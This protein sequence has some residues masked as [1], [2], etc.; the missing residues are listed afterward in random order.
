MKIFLAFA[1][2]LG[3]LSLFSQPVLEHTFSESAAFCQL[4]SLGEVFYAMDVVNKQ[5]LIYDMDHTLLRTISL[6]TPEGYYL[7]DIQYVSETLFNS[8]N[9]VELVYIYSKYVPTDYSYYYTFETRLVNENGSILLTLPGVGFTQ[10]V[11]TSDQKKKFLA[12]EYNYSVI[13]YATKTHVYNLPDQST[14]SASQFINPVGLGNAYPNPANRQVFIPFTMPE[15]A[16]SG[17]LLLSDMNGKKVLSYPINSSADHVLLPTSQF[18]PGTY[19][20]HL[21]T[22]LGRSEGKKVV[23]R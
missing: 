7:A 10:V 6:P 20:Y 3:S 8:D 11:E 18:A 5:C 22:D 21:D 15:G 2:W 12:Y 14:K 9:L 16:Q 19:I 1:I 13:P 23:I 17:T 4:K